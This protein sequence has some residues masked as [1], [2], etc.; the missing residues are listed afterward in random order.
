MSRGGGASTTVPTA[1]VNAS[2]LAAATVVV[3][4]A[5]GQ[6]I[7][8]NAADL[9]KFIKSQNL[10][11]ASGAK[12]VQSHHSQTAIH[13]GGQDIAQER[14]RKQDHERQLFELRLM[15]YEDYQFLP[16][17]HDRLRRIKENIEM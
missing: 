14:L 12:L 3:P 4:E 13:V 10:H 8:S 2:S 17:E 16:A 5:F 1:V 7:P 9:L 6:A 15:S 11:R